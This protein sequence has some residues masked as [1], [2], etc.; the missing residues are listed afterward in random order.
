MIRQAW[1]ETT[2]KY[3]LLDLKGEEKGENKEPVASFV[4]SSTEA[5]GARVVSLE[6]KNRGL[7]SKL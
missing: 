5:S 1:D 2:G 7:E 6:L 3:P 4:L